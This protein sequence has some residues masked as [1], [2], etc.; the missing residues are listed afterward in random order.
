MILV[1][2]LPGVPMAGFEDYDDV[3]LT[4]HLSVTY[5]G[6][7]IEY[8]RYE[9]GL[10]VETMDGVEYWRLTKREE[11]QTIPAFPARDCCRWVDGI[12]VVRLG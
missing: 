6:G 12:L 2:N 7:A 1:G 10:P 8:I 9:L 4:G 5:W 11:V 3:G